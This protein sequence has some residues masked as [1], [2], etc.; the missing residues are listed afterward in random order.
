MTGGVNCGEGHRTRLREQLMCF[1][2]PPAPVYKGREE[3]A[4]GQEGR[5]M[6]ESPTRTPLLVGFGPPLFPSHAGG[7]REGE[8]EGEWKGGP[9]PLPLV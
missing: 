4:T 2:V 5:A 9:R 6:G 3:E 8:G 1:G 7:K